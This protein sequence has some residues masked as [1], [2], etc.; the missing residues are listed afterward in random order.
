MAFICSSSNKEY[1]KYSD[2]KALQTLL[3]TRHIDVD[4]LCI[5]SALNTGISIDEDFD[6]LFILGN[7]AQTDMFQLAARV[8]IGSSNR[9]YKTV[10]C[11]V[12][13]RNSLKFRMESMML[14][15]TYL[16]EPT[17]WQIQKRSQFAPTYMQNLT[18]PI[19]DSEGRQQF[20]SEG[21]PMTK[22]NVVVNKMK[23]CKLKL[24]IKE[25]KSLLSHG[26]LM[27]AYRFLFEDRYFGICVST[28]RDQK[29]KQVVSQIVTILK[30]YRHMGWL[31]ASHRKDL[32]DLCDENGLFT[33]HSKINALLKEHGS[34]VRIDSAL[35]KFKGV[36]TQ[37]WRVLSSE[38]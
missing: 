28:L 22:V 29:E 4:L 24:D 38:C 25:F 26:N 11:S 9:H 7:S 2:R 31:S 36:A 27:D 16:K 15:L 20:D 19:T 6:Y 12:P 37:T 21:N 23:L 35:R 18:T 30:S 17:R 14:D 34:D 32:K 8:R 3:E 1:A 10:Y 5:T 33:T 13:K